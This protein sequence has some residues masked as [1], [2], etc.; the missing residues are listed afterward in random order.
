MIYTYKLFKAFPSYFTGSYI[1]H[2]SSF[3]QQSTVTECILNLLDHPQPPPPQL[4]GVGAITIFIDPEST[5]ILL[6]MLWVSALPQ[7]GMLVSI[8]SP[9]GYFCYKA[10][11][12]LYAGE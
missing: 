11:S 3:C 5:N 9:V 6:A 12:L 2:M 4:L 10:Y 8:L 7:K 1:C